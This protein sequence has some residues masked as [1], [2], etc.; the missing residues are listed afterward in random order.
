MPA[1][2]SNLIMP[3]VEKKVALGST[4]IGYGF[5]IAIGRLGLQM[6]DAGAGTGTTTYTS[7]PI[8]TLYNNQWHHVA[9]TVN[10]RGNPAGI[11]WYLDGA[12]ISTS[13][14]T[15]PPTRYGSLVNSAPLR[16][17]STI[18]PIMPGWLWFKGDVDELEIF[19]RELTQAEVKSIFTAGTAGKCK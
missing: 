11:S 2:S 9:V 1:S 6:A 8:S 7:V 10:R 4:W 19:N 5:W 13:N 17:G 14:P 18:P 3:L 16:I 15:T 12:V